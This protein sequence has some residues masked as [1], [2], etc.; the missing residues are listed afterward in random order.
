MTTVIVVVGLIVVVLVVVTL[1]ARRSGYSGIGGDTV[2]RCRKDHLFT[3][4]WTPG[5]SFKAV[6]LGLTRLQWCPVG[7]HFSIVRPINDAELTDEQ[8]REAARHHDL[9]IP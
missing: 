5:V 6:R 8:K 7:K 1:A 2:V 9:R 3:T 4:I